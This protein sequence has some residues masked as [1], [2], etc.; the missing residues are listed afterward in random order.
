[1]L[2]ASAETV[3]IGTFVF[4]KQYFPE[5]DAPFAGVNVGFSEVRSLTQNFTNST[6][7][8]TRAPFVAWA[9]A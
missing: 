4:S 2:V 1:M 5:P 3:K 6:A 7:P 8:G 9:I